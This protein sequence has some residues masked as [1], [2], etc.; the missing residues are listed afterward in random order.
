MALADEHAVAA[1]ELLAQ[2]GGR[3][4][5]GRRAAATVVAVVAV[6]GPATPDEPDEQELRRAS[7][8]TMTATAPP[9]RRDM[10]GESVT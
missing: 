5:P 6:D 3:A 7:A 10:V 2:V 1:G 4:R 8:A 9:M